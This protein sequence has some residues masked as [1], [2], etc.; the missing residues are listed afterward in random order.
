M[1]CVAQILGVAAATAGV[2]TALAGATQG[3]DAQ[4]AVA[5]A[6]ASDPVNGW[7][8]VPCQ[9]MNKS[10]ADVAGLAATPAAIGWYSDDVET[11]GWGFL[12]VEATN[13]TGMSQAAKSW[14]AGCIEGELTGHRMSQY[15]ANYAANEYGAAGPSSELVQWMSQQLAYARAVAA[16]K[17]GTAAVTPAVAAQLGLLLAQFDGLATAAGTSAGMTREQVMLLNAVGDLEDLNGIFPNSKSLRGA[18]PGVFRAGHRQGAAPLPPKAQ[19]DLTDCSA[20]VGLGQNDVYMGH[21]TW[22]SYYAMLRTYKVYAWPWAPAKT[23]SFSSSPGLLCSK[24][25]FYATAHGLVVVETTFSVFNTSVWS[26]LSANTLLSWQRAAVA[27]AIA[28]SPA[29][30]GDMFKQA[31]SGTYSNG[32]IVLNMTAATQAA[33]AMPGTAWQ[34]PAGS[35]WLHEQAPGAFVSTDVSGIA[36]SQRWFGGW[37][38]PLSKQLFNRLGYPAAVAKYGPSYTY[39]G[40][41]RAHIFARNGTQVRSI[42]HAGA[43]L[44]YNNF[45]HDPL[46]NGDPMAA[47]SS[48]AD[49]R[50]TNAVAF[51][52][53]DSKVV[54][55]GAM[56]DTGRVNVLAQSGPTYDQ[57]PDFTFTGAFS[58]IVRDGVPT[59]FHFPWMNISIPAVASS[60]AEHSVQVAQ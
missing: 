30:W 32:W 22:R 52:G 47:V 19:A 49:L 29:E 34:L 17:A 11:A 38:I 28:S 21:T 18:H 54:A 46:A 60:V 24:D 35:L 51:G 37:N 36:S 9:V 56:L 39:E 43:L 7:A 12:S 5:F 45:E 3:S 25:D 48:R 58:G 27:T 59:V 50:S 55:G 53:V 44:R 15:W 33:R 14:A 2:A 31:N 1:R 6:P 20:Y 10:A 26:S 23:I 4:W 57:Q 16:G 40:A 8:S 41:P 42:E 13:A